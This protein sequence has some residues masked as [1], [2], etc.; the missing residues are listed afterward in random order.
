MKWKI[1][2][3]GF[4]NVGQALVRILHAKKGILKKKYSFDFKV[5][6]IADPIK[7]S[8][9]DENGLDLKEIVDLLNTKG[10]IRDYSRGITDLDSIKMIK[11]TNT[12]LIV[13][14]TPT[15]VK[16]GEPGLTHIKTALENKK[17]VVTTNKGPIALAYPELMKLAKENN[18]Y[19]RFEGTVL[20]GTPSINLALEA[21]A[22]CDILKV[23][24]IVNGTTNFILTKM[25][26]GMSYEDALKEAQRLGYAEAD[27]TADVEG[28][29]AAVKTVIIANVMMGGDITIKDVD[30]KGIT[31]ITLEDVKKAKENKKRIKLIAEVYREGEKIKARVSPK[32]LPLTHPLANVMGA[33]NALT[34]TTDHLGDVTIIG[35]GAGRIETGQALLNDILA[36]HRCYSCSH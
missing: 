26:E 8:V 18:V 30:R 6:A 20:S 27:P 31:E 1:G 22:G 11:E 13:E 3:I 5:M 15:N 7:G 32:E 23:Q 4:G 34:F 25:E 28:W 14:A 29:D 35:P 16:T 10:N 19:L 24:G 36:I 21:L 12:N 17:H 2:I 33:I 9:Y